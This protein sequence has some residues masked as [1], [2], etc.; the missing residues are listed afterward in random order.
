M[1]LIVCAAF[2]RAC[3]P[4]H[5]CFRGTFHFA[6][7]HSWKYTGVSASMTQECVMKLVVCA[8]DIVTYMVSVSPILN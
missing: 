6:L 1:N 2:S 3:L 5:R 7:Q 4:N 8:N